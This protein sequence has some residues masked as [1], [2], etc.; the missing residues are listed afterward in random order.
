MDGFKSST[1]FG[2]NF[3]LFLES[4]ADNRIGELLFQIV[5]PCGSHEVLQV[6]NCFGRWMNRLGYEAH[7]EGGAH[8]ADGI[9]S[10]GAVGTQSFV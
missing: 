7:S 10:W 5:I 3:G 9:K 8:P 2:E 6:S 1:L 4:L